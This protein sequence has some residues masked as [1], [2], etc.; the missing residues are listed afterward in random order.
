MTK[1]LPIVLIAAM[2][3]LPADYPDISGKWQMTAETPHGPVKGPLEIKQDG[4]KFTGTYTAEPF[5]S[6]RSTAS[7]SAD[8]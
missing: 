8:R 2:P 7:T 3:A 4:A 1:L 5:G 6:R